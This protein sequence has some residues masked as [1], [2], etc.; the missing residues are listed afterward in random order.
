MKKRAKSS[1]QNQILEA[2]R[3]KRQLE[4]AKQRNLKIK[5]KQIAQ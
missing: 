4:R 2:F 5:N 3:E 1:K